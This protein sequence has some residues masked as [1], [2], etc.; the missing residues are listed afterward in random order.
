MA[1]YVQ[2]YTSQATGTYLPHSL[3]LSLSH[4]QS[5]SH[6]HF[7]SQA[8]SLSCPVR[9][10]WYPYPTADP[11]HT[12]MPTSKLF[13][14]F[15]KPAPS[16]RLRGGTN[17]SCPSTVLSRTRLTPFK[18]SSTTCSSSK[19]WQSRQQPQKLK[20]PPFINLWVI[21]FWTSCLIRTS[22][23]A[24]ITFFTPHQVAPSRIAAQ[25]HPRVASCP[26][27]TARCCR[28]HTP[29]DKGRHP[30]HDL[31]PSWQHIVEPGFV[32]STALFSLPI[33]RLF[34]HARSP[35]RPLARSP[36]TTCAPRLSSRPFLVALQQEPDD[37]VPFLAF[38][39]YLGGLP[40]V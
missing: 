25:Y 16:L 37:G 38:A 7:L 8:A 9:L 40:V 4:S 30:P 32:V 22:R 29:S 12:L 5:L 27:S 10:L 31:I 34:S 26:A 39:A 24:S 36:F 15:I 1:G 35:A 23:Q 18:T 3:S 11:G 13:S 33:C 19:G 14:L 28:T 20:L 21:V 2:W 6:T 17:P